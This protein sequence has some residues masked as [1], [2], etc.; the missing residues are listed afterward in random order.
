MEAIESLRM[1][2]EENKSI[3]E[4]TR[5]L[6]ILIEAKKAQSRPVQQEIEGFAQSSD[7]SINGSLDRNATNSNSE[8]GE[9]Y[10]EIDSLDQDSEL[11]DLS[12]SNERY[13]IPNIKTFRPQ[14]PLFVSFKRKDVKELKKDFG[15]CEKLMCAAL[16]SNCHLKLALLVE[17]VNFSEDIKEHFGS[18]LQLHLN[19]DHL[20]QKLKPSSFAK[21]VH[22]A[23][24][25]LS[26]ASHGSSKLN[27]NPNG[28]LLSVLEVKPDAESSVTVF[29][30]LDKVC[31]VDFENDT[32]STFDDTSKNKVASGLASIANYQFIDILSGVKWARSCK[33]G[34]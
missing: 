5:R 19:S 16:N 28:K 17:E 29:R 13:F 8:A 4:N 32:V 11:E 27:E 12:E 24:E 9:S 6:I 26:D 34:F 7:A 10:E 33:T 25:S 23:L 18:E 22:F 21:C 2:V 30:H 1:K 15:N 20:K 14:K 3:C 31:F